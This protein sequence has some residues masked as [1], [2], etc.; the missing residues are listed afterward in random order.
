MYYV[1]IIK[2]T[3]ES[4]WYT[5]HTSH[6]EN[7]LKIHNSGKVKSTKSF[8]CLPKHIDMDSL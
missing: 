1:Y 5:G 2:S 4:H 7:R 6:L 3:Q 8:P